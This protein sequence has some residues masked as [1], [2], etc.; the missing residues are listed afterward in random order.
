M[1]YVSTIRFQASKPIMEKRRRARINESLN[2]LKALI[3][4]AVRKDVSLCFLD[5][6]EQFSTAGL[7]F[8]LIARKFK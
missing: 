2:E 1:L 8:S 5:E 4:E 7:L 6:E 3:L